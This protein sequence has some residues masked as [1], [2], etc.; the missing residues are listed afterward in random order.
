MALQSPHGTGSVP[1]LYRVHCPLTLSPY[2][3]FWVCRLEV[4]DE[5]VWAVV[6]GVGKVAEWLLEGETHR[7]RALQAG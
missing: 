3:D 4:A 7:P 2:G 6:E 5:G 1:T